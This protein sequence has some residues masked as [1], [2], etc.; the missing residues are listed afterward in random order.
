[1]PISQRNK[2]II[3][4]L[5]KS[6]LTNYDNL[7]LIFQ[8]ARNILTDD[9]DVEEA[10]K[11]SENVK[12]ISKS[13]MVRDAKFIDLYYKSLLLEAPYKFESF[14]LYMEKNRPAEKQFYLPR[15]KT[16][17]TIVDDLQDLEDGKLDFLGISLPPRVG[18]LISDD[19]PVLTLDGWKNHGDLKVG[20]YVFDYDGLPVK[21]IHVFPKYYANKRVWFSDG[22]YIDCHENHEWIIYDRHKQQERIAE[23]KELTALEYIEP[24]SKKRRYCYQIPL[25][26][27]LVGSVK[28]LP[29]K[30][31]TLGVWLGDGRNGN[32]D[33]CLSK[34]DYPIV[35]SIIDNGYEISWHTT[36]KTTDVEYYGFKSLRKDLQKIGL[37]HSRKYNEKYIPG[38]YLS[39][40]I[41]QRLELL[42]GLLDTDGCLRKKEHRYDFTTSE[43]KLKEDFISLVSTFGWRCSVKEILPHRSSSGINGRKKYWV[44]SFNP[45]YPIPCRLKRKQLNDFSKKRRIAITKIEDI[46]PK[47]G[48]CI[49]VQGG[50]YRVGRRCIPTHNS[51]LC[52]FFLAWVMG[53][54]PNSHNAMGG[55]S[56]ILAKGFYGEVL[57]LMAPPDKSEYTF[58]EI[59]PNVKLESK[60]ADEFT[61]NLDKPDRFAT[62]TCRGIDGTWTGAIDISSDGYLYVDDL[63]RDRTESLSPTRLN[64]RYQDYLNV[65]VDRKND[66]SR[67][68]MV[69]T[70]WNILD[71]LGRVEKDK[72]DNPRY[73]FRKIP[74]LNENGESNFQYDYGVGFSTKYYQDIKAR[75]DKNEWEA[76]YQQRPFVREGLLF[77]EDELRFFNGILPEGGFVRVVSV[78][79]IAWGG[80]DALSQPIGAEYENGDVYIFDW[81][82]NRGAKE[83]TIPIVAGKIM[84][85][86]IQQTHF[87]AN[88]GGE[89]Y[90]KYIDDFL[91]EK[92]YKCS[93]TYSKAPS[94]MAKMAKI[95][96]Y[97]G[98]IKRRFIFLAPNSVIRKAAENDAPGTK[99]YYRSAEYDEAMDELT[100]FVQ[101]GKNEHDD[102]ADS[103]SQLERFI[104]GGFTAKGEV[105]DRRSLGI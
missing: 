30:P 40:S 96:Q 51:T 87:E 21:V 37:C 49:A 64:N 48:N 23:T 60:S 58:Y 14:L 11:V 65:M 76:K 42:A 59:F 44:I 71:P 50:I 4:K 85:N 62:L 53:K 33:I 86:G 93:I 100:T 78:A 12:R 77:P 61:V 102:A 47:H 94:E 91:T 43:E 68:L 19:T 29:V 57:N 99:R 15:R 67:E 74:A 79:D 89:M 90:A 80:G 45:T 101:I 52:I 46:E 54:R 105:F 92:K 69:G 38:I 28:D 17:K 5:K 72:K 88:N 34:D 36:H 7:Y 97:S 25:Y 56:G 27:P 16:L 103:L 1:M 10:M 18:K 75:L 8:T 84:G 39:S 83:I 63:V 2:Q 32:P 73:R 104:E 24:K 70:R 6:D 26:Q 66:G 9:G 35:Q 3:D 98:D 22:S 20:D 31:Y 55:H 41:P 81:T 95:I 82:F 13:L